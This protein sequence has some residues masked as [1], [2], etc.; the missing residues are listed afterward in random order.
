V[1]FSVQLAKTDLS[2]ASV[3]L[4]LVTFTLPRAMYTLF[5]ALIVAFR[6]H[7]LPSASRR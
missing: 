6:N 2:A 4:Q 7:F 5:F 3:A 1:F